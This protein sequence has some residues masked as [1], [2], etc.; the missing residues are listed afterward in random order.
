[1]LQCFCL[2][3]RSEARGSWI[4]Y[5]FVECCGKLGREG[6]PP[7][8]LCIY[9]LKRKTPSPDRIPPWLPRAWHRSNLS[10]ICARP[11]PASTTLMLCSW[12][13]RHLHICISKYLHSVDTRYLHNVDTRYLHSVD[14]RYRAEI[15]T[16]QAGASTSIIFSDTVSH[17]SL[18]SAP[19]TAL[20]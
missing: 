11:L 9:N 15:D 1:M 14:T 12:I 4:K 8:C 3:L 2:V 17:P 13:S 6:K 18:T 20:I 7:P 19:V 5:L 10:I 16:R